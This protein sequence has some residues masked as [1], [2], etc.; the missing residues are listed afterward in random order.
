MSKSNKQP[1][2]QVVGSDNSVFLKRTGQYLKFGDLIEL[3]PEEAEL[4]VGEN[5]VREVTPQH[6]DIDETQE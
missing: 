3:T 5:L 6:Q 4:L 1:I 2:Y